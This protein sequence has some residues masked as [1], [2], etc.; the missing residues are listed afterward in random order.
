MSLR[1]DPVVLRLDEPTQAFVSGGVSINLASCDTDRWPS[2]SRCCGCRV[3]ASGALIRLMLQRQQGEDVLRDVE[4]TGR[5]AIVFSDVVSHRTLQVKGSRAYVDDVGPEDRTAAQ[6]YLRHFAASLDAIGFEPAFSAALL[7]L[8]D[9][10]LVV[11]AVRPSA[12]F[13]QTPGPG[14][15]QPLGQ[16][17]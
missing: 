2:V 10:D 6:R 17:Q 11:V 15:G 14:A 8:N 5:A 3:T 9:D 13:V 4:A 12:L 1:A 7:D 16:G